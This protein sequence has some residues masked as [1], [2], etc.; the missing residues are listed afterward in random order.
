MM[1]HVEGPP[2]VM[3]LD[4]ELLVVRAVRHGYE[5]AI[6][7]SEPHEANVEAAA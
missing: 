4:A 3:D 1:K 5:H 2:A 6:G 7:W